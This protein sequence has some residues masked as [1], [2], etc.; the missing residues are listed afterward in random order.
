[1]IKKAPHKIILAH[2]LIHAFHGVQGKCCK[3]YEKAE[4]I[5][6]SFIN[7]SFYKNYDKMESLEELKVIGVD[8]F[9]REKL[10]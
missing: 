6:V 10:N 5:Y 8:G 2:E 7:F 4:N 9:C 3:P 1:M